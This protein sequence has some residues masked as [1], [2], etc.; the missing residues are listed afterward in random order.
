MNRRKFMRNSFKFGVNAG[1]ASLIS[2]FARL[3]VPDKPENDPTAAAGKNVSAKTKPRKAVV[4]S[5]NKDDKNNNFDNYI[6][7]FC[8]R[9]YCGRHGQR[10]VCPRAGSVAGQP[11]CG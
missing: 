9:V 1:T 7:S 3:M 10:A 4:K 2:P 5:Q 11:P 6:Y 8:L